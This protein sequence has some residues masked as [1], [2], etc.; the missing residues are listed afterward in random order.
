M[1][2]AFSGSRINALPRSGQ[3]IRVFDMIEP[4]MPDLQIRVGDCPTGVDRY[5]REECV[6]RKIPVSVFV[7]DWRIHGTRA[8]PMR[9][10]L[11]LLG[12]HA[13]FALP[14]LLHE[15]QSKGTRNAIEEAESLG[16]P[17]ARCIAHVSQLLKP[18][19]DAKSEK[20][21]L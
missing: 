15:G 10:R 17:V 19:L 21:S 14:C 11:M 16:I 3:I 18:L 2:I 7:A 13:L 12:S 20:A 1:I 9:N 6:K 4:L 5:V 8:G